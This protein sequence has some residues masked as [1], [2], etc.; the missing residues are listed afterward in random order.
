MNFK[1][2][3]LL[4]LLATPGALSAT[5][6]TGDIIA[7]TTWNNA[8]SP[9][10][11]NPAGASGG[12]I[13]VRNG[14][15]LTIDSSGGAVAIQWNEDCDFKIGN[16]S[17][18]QGTLVI[19]AASG[20]VTFQIKTG[21]NVRIAKQLGKMTREQRIAVKDFV[22]KEI[23]QNKLADRLQTLEEAVA[24]IEHELE[25]DTDMAA[26]LIRQG[27]IDDARNVLAK[28]IAREREAEKTLKDMEAVENSLADVVQTVR[29]ELIGSV[30][31]A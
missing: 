31:A 19:K 7:D 13:T 16:G 12:T 1:L 27:L 4:I 21:G 8:G 29:E 14:K 10:V 2:L 20:A 9:Y 24:R 22:A 15:T 28:A 3:A 17:S 25:A 26:T 30:G 11:L 18:E 6:I 5:T 23:E